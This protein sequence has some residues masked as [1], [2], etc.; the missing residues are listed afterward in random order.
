MNFEVGGVSILLC[1]SEWKQ[2]Y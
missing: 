1:T 2:A